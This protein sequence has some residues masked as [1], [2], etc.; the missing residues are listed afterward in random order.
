MFGA[1]TARGQPTMTNQITEKTNGTP[2]TP[3]TAVAV[4]PFRLFARTPFDSFD[5]MRRM[6][7]SL[8]EEAAYPELGVQLEPAVNLYENDGTYTLECAVPGY[9]KDDITVEARGD[10]VTISGS[11]AQEKTDEKNRYHRRE[12]RQGSFTR[13]V[14][15]PQEVDPDQVKAKLENG[16]LKIELHPKQ[17]IKSKTIPVTG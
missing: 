8:F 3:R 1:H 7:D 6:M 2:A 17:T 13:T 14:E 11:Y 10:H 16:M 5:A 9:K 15:L 4:R 12:L